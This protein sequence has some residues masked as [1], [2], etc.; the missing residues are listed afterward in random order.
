[1][2][3][4]EIELRS[5][6]VQEVMGQIPAWILR[7]GITV[8]FVIVLALLIVSYFFKYPDTLQTD[9]TLTGNHPAAQLVARNNGKLQHLFVKDGEKVS[10]N[11]YLAVIENPAVAEDIF[12]LKKSLQSVTDM[13]DSAILLF[14][15]AK[16]LSLGEIQ[17]SYT[18]FL[19]SLQEY[20]NHKLLNYYPQKKEVLA[21]QIEKYRIYLENLKR[22]HMVVQEQYI[23]AHDRYSRDSALYAR[24]V[25]SLFEYENARTKFLQSKHSLESSSASIDNTSIQITSMEGS[26]LDIESQQT[27]KE[28]ILLHEFRSTTEQ[29]LNNIN[30]WELNYA[31]KSPIKG[32]V[33]FTKFWSINQNISSGEVVCTVIPETEDNILGKALLPLQNSGKVK[34]GQRVIVRFS[35]FPDQEF[36]IV[37]GTVSAISLVPL[38][39]NYT[40]EIAFPNGLTTNYR[41]T[42]P[43]SPEM[44]A[45][46][47]IITDDLRLIE[48]LFMP[49]KKI[50]KEGFRN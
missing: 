45:S 50:L 20:S 43:V 1:M 27:E 41:K 18:T 26:L 33:T 6:E 24:S 36:G 8:L 34:T 2:E 39:G 37:N 32:T 23:I 5:E 44:Q 13:P 17:S 3:N 9:M 19:R 40:I 29:L 10:E 15:P 42:L 14:L 35:N 30:S 4:K 47:E 16:E 7:W 46:A 48:R 38:D 11:Q 49:L 31:I 12:N 28:N 25:T 22:Q 21:K